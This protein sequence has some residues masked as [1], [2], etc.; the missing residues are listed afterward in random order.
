[1][2][3][4]IHAGATGIYHVVNGG[5]TT[6]FD[7]AREIFRLAEMEVSLKPITTAEY[8]APAPRPGYSVLSTE[9]Y[10][11]T[12]GPAM[13]SWQAALARFLQARREA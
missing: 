1:M 3:H 5:Q 2:R 8:G 13:P 6:W 9:K 7:F 12:G 11:A 4:L 10:H